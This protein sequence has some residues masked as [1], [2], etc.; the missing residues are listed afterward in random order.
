MAQLH[1][2]TTRPAAV[3][4]LFYPR[5]P[6]ELHIAVET[7]LRAVPQLEPA[8]RAPKAIVAPHA[9]YIYSGPIAASVYALLEPARGRIRRVVLLGPT[10]RVA[11]NGLAL[12]DAEAFVTP[13]GRVAIDGD[14]VAAVSRLPQ[15]TRSAAA[16]AYEHSLEVQ[17]PFLQSVLG[18][19]TLV[20]FAVGY[21]G[22]G[23]V[24]EVLDMLWGGAETLIVVSSDLSHYH[25]YDE[26]QAI[27]RGTAN[28][29]LA[30]RTD[31]TH[32]QACGATPVAGI[33]LAAGRRGLRAQLVDLRNSGDTAGDRGRVVGYGAFAY[34]EGRDEH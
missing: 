5:D 10:H 22:P 19:F 12:P 33:N 2:R 24:A 34:F 7:M 28:A 17:L 15:V 4:G 27:D 30:L 6:G 9:G 18:T 21:A 20:P 32:E 26:A 11:V 25:P 13:M 8:G 29:I 3:A 23:E 14:A 31:I 1:K 16:H